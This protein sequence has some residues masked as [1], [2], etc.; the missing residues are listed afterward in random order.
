[1]GRLIV[2]CDGCGERILEEDIDKGNA[3]Q[4]AG[5]YY[6]ARC[7]PA[8][9]PVTPHKVPAPTPSHGKT[10]AVKTSAVHKVSTSRHTARSTAVR[11]SSMPMIVGAVVAGVA[12]IALI[13]FAVGG[14]GGSGGEPSPSH[15]PPGG[16]SAPDPLAP[17]KKIVESVEE[18]A[19]AH[20]NDPTEVLRRVSDALAKVDASLRPRLERVRADA[21]AGLKTAGAAKVVDEYLQKARDEWKQDPEFM[22]KSAVRGILDDARNAGGGFPTL[23][24]KVAAAETEYAKAFNDAAAKAWKTVSDAAEEIINSRS[25]PLAAS[26]ELEKLPVQFL[27]GE[28]ER[29][30]K[31]KQQ[32]YADRITKDVPKAPKSSLWDDYQRGMSF[33]AKDGDYAQG[34]RIVEDV[35]RRLNDSEEVRTAAL[36]DGQVREIAQNGHYNVACYYSRDQKDPSTACRFLEFALRCGYS[37]WEHID[38]DKDLDA[39]RKSEPFKDLEKKYRNRKTMGVECGPARV[40]TDSGETGGLVVRRVVAGSVAEKGGIKDGDCIMEVDRKSLPLENTLE[41]FRE[42]ITEIKEETDVPVVVIRNSQKVTLTLKW[43]KAKK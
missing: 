10:T 19:R 2:Y 39:V 40:R 16:K 9:A 42:I 41:R 14:R 24:D 7:R 37:D 22:R 1:M 34:A 5:R 20:P 17:Q 21:E 35:L 28:W 12:V 36:S 30:L 3:T 6:C 29:K 15:E 31:Q 43:P 23:I 18:W 26:R 33:F 8:D 13:A 11:R 27:E 25:D 32:E 38:K 4:A